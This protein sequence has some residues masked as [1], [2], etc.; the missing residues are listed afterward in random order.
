L[1]HLTACP[2]GSYKSYLNNALERNCISGRETFYHEQ[3]EMYVCVMYKENIL[4]T[5]N[6]GKSHI[7][8]CIRIK[9]GPMYAAASFATK[10]CCR[11]L[12]TLHIAEN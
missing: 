5:A 7:I 6:A 12:L 11:E 2:N 4:C 3:A 1:L 9:T 8:N 10:K